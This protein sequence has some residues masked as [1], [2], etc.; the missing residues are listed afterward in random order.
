MTTA[1]VRR[2]LTWITMLMPCGMPATG[3]AAEPP[4]ATGD[5][6]G[7]QVRMT[8]Q[9]VIDPEGLNFARGPWGT[10]INGQTFQEQA[11]ATHRGWQYAT[12]FHSS[13]RLAIARRPLPD[14]PWQHI[15]FDDYRI[16]HNDVHNV[17]V[18]GI[19]PGDGTIHLAFDHHGHPLHYRVSKAGAATQPGRFAWDANLFGPT[20]DTLDG[21]ERLQRM[22]YPMF[23]PASDDG[24]LLYY[25]TGGSGDGDWHLT[26]YDP[27]SSRWAR[28][29]VFLAKG[30]LFQGDSSR[31]AYLNGLQ[32][33]ARGR[34]HVSWCWRE[35]PDLKSNHDLLYASSDDRGRTWQNNAGQTIARSGQSPIRV[36]SPGIIAAPIAFGWGMMNQLTQDVDGQ[37]RVHVVLWHNPPDAPGPNHDL[38]AW[39]YFHYWRDGARPWQRQALPFFGRKPRLVVNEAGDAL[40]VF[41]K[42]ADL[43]YHDRDHGGRLHVAAATAETQWTDWRVVYTSDRDY[44]G[45]P[46]VDMLR[47]RAEHM[48]S[49]Y[50]QQKPAQ[51]G[52]P[53]PLWLI[54][55]HAG[56]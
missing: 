34:L 12:Y 22:T 5:E 35:T 41:N 44:V 56:P 4:W 55:L 37:S 31:C 2:F 8:A 28:P 19:C 38:N 26:E 42:G 6:G 47:W 21:A 18:L 43:E 30:G 48:L 50:V 13:G 45:E 15:H 36:D 20:T 17:A 32:Y 49:V 14:G 24:L 39:R 23:A 53:S 27:A 40:L 16:R 33:D 10:C 46:R 25:R 3:P 51:P 9:T 11:V 7:F 1:P 54:D 52:Q 29:R